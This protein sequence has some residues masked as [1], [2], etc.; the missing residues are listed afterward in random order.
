M[1]I[2]F[3]NF[4]R[5]FKKKLQ[6]L[7]I[8]ILPAIL[9][10]LVST[11]IMANKPIVK[12]GIIDLDKTN[13]TTTLT[14]QLA[15]QTDSKEVTQDQI[16]NEL[17]NSKVDYVVVLDK[18]FTERLIKGEDVE[19]KGYYLKDSIQALPVQNYLDSYFSSAKRIAQAA[20]GDEQ[21]FN[22]G[23][24]ISKDADLQLDYKILTGIERQKSYV[25]LGIFLEIILMTTVIFTTLILTDKANKTIYRTLTAPVSLRRYMFQNILSFLLV[26]II[27]VTI[28]FGV[29][30]GCLGIYMGDSSLNMFLLVL[31]ASVLAVSIG[32]AVSSMSKSVI[33]ASF[34][35]LFI[36]FF[37]GTLGGTLW[38]HETAT[39]LLNTIGKFTP[40]YWIMDGVSKLLKDRG[41]FAISG[42]ILI[43]LLFALVFFFLGTWRKEDIAK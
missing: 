38:E 18:G 25:T 11:S 32:V 28:G 17:V 34:T 7:V 36:A 42:D 27:Q 1:T 16:Q 15:L 26:S 9:L 13:Y 21:R 39:V 24:K 41:L 8:L 3:N 6:V 19:A 4:R 20:G 37:M 35:G 22:E 12:I 23:L 10:T 43:I 5:I 33:Q 29:L 2:F 30:K 40:V 14:N 31:T